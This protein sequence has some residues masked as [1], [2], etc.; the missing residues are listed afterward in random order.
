MPETPVSRSKVS[1]NLGLLRRKLA[2][3][4]MWENVCLLLMWANR[5]NVPKNHLL[6]I[7]QFVKVLYFIRYLPQKETE[8]L[9]L[10]H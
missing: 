6:L 5:S 10:C 3:Y 7:L 2:K 9:L 8:I 1:V 4:D